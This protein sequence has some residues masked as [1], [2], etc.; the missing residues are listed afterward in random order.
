MEGGK[1]KPET[2]QVQEVAYKII[3][4]FKMTHFKNGISFQLLELEPKTKL[5]V[6]VFQE[7]NKVVII[8]E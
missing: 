4:L 5:R 8:Q 6:F 7:E 2:F 1:R 3:V